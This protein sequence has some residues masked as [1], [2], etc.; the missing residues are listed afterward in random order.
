[1]DAADL[2][3][4]GDTDAALAALQD[5]VRA[6]PGDAG[7]RVFLAHLLAVRGDWHRAVKQ[8]DVAA[9]LDASRVVLAQALRLIAS[10]ERGRAR[11]F[12][13]ESQPLIL[14][15]PSPWVGR[16]AEAIARSARGEHASAGVLRAE[17]LEEAPAAPG[18]I[19]LAP[20]PGEEAAAAHAFEW[21]A[22]ADPRLGP[23]L[24][25]FIDGRY[26]W[27]PMNRVRELRVHAP[28]DLLDLVAVPADFVWTNGGEAGGFIPTRYPG[29]EAA[30]DALRL[31]RRTEWAEDAPGAYRGLGQ[32]ELAT[33][34][35]EFALLSVRRFR[36]HLA[37][38]P[39]A[40]LAGAAAAEARSGG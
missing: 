35:G 40:P 9:E 36:Q 13:G 28:A 33:D 31:A 23:I 27:V 3:R 2:I 7:L 17:A 1:M 6:A 38:Q 12:A 30:A 16:L 20:A 24:E 4:S 11:V 29:S 21:A 32:R 39:A 15:E 14:G 34:S 25:A 37:E 26:Y 19:E 8:I 18:S 10:C 22:D 5:Q